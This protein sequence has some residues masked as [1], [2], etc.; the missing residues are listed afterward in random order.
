MPTRIVLSNGGELTVDD[1]PA[2][3]AQRLRSESAALV[4]VEVPTRTGEVRTAWVNPAHVVV[5]EEARAES[6]PLQSS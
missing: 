4:G 5:V 6:S 2:S 3:V 1:E